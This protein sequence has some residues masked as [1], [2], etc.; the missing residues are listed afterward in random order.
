MT[1]DAKE[2]WTPRA[3]FLA[4]RQA[5]TPNERAQLLDEMCAGQYDLR[6]QVEEML[7]AAQSAQT[8]PLDRL[9]ASLNPTKDALAP[10]AVDIENHPV[11]GPYKLLEQIGEGGMGVVYAALQE[12]PIRRIVAL[13]I[14]KP[15]MDSRQV[16]ARFDVE[17]Q[18]LA[19]MSHPHIAKELDAGATNSGSPYFVMELVK[20]IPITEFCDQRLAR[21]PWIF[22][23]I[24]MAMLLLQCLHPVSIACAKQCTNIESHCRWSR[25]IILSLT[26]G[27][28]VAAM[29]TVRANK[30]SAGC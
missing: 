1:A 27:L 7:F 16:L 23:D 3:I 30:K 28:I 18:S 22:D 11:I 14:I 20:G 5:A 19:M 13:K 24:W 6:Q 4:V 9:A 12:Q 26:L 17:R 2:K 25:S 10:L 29:Q 21:L 8:N 15:G